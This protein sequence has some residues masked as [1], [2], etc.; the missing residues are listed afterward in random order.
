[1]Q[2]KVIASSFAHRSILANQRDT[3]FGTG[4]AGTGMMNLP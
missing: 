1:M 3:G 4:D 2:F